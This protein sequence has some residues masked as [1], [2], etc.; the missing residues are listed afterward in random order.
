M[1]DHTLIGILQKYGTPTY[2]F[3][4]GAFQRRIREVRDI[5]GEHIA[6]CYSVKANPFLIP[7]AA[8]AADRLEVCSPGE[9]EICENLSV[10]MEK[11]VYSGVNK[12]PGDVRQAIGDAVGCCTAESLRHVKILN[13]EALRAGKTVPVLLRLNHRSQFGMS[14]EDLLS[15]IDRRKEYPG[16]AIEG[17]HYF[18]GT[19]RRNRDLHQQKEEL[20]ML[21]DLFREV[22]EQHGYELKKLEYGP[23]LPVPLFV[24]DDFSDTL[25][26]ARELAPALQHAAEFAEL[27]VEAGRFLATEC[28]YYLTRIM[29][30]KTAGDKHYCIADGGIHH[31]NY[32]GQLMGMKT[33]VIC[34]YQGNGD[35]DANPAKVSYRRI[36]DDE[37]H[38]YALCGSLCTTNDDLVRSVR[39][40]EIRPGDVLAFEN[41]GAYSVTEAMYLF[42]SRDLPR[43]VLVQQDG[44]W[45]LA[46]DVKKTSPINTVCGAMDR[47]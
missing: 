30:Q 41:I 19:Q 18:V 39:M 43:V 8:E 40:A 11:V 14:R 25:A 29:D 9:L 45:L 5:L 47:R 13:A 34:H 26:P 2:V 32:L 21:E 22:R 16:I 35:P 37:S 44:S 10:P 28:G 3:D 1:E 38:E 17:I 23:G 24:G 31:V 6:L 4:T 27:T 15:V 20:R 42:L 46:R 36:P 33:P 12:E 7:A